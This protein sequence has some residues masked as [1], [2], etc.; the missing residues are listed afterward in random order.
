MLNNPEQRI[1]EINAEL[2]RRGLLKEA[3]NQQPQ[4]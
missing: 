2:K 1:N 4:Q 3:S